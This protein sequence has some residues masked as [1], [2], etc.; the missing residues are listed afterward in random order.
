MSPAVSHLIGK[1]L[2][3]GY[4]ESDIEKIWYF[5]HSEVKMSVEE[6]RSHTLVL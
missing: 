5:G 1:T 6:F 3:K 4:R 2:N